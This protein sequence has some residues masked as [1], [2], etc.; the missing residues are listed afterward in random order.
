MIS[1][2][3]I[4]CS[5]HKPVL[6]ESMNSKA[7]IMFSDS[8]DPPTTN[9]NKVDDS[10]TSV[11]KNIKSGIL[12]KTGGETSNLVQSIGFLLLLISVVIIVSII[13]N[14]KNRERYNGS[15]L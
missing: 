12:P 5:F 6:A 8:Y 10:K 3:L 2:F 4:V 14:Y 13:R 9:P 1:S 11:D 7:G 15:G